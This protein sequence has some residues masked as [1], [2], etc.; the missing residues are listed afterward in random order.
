M[1]GSISA[2]VPFTR[3]VPRGFVPGSL[4]FSLYTIPLCTLLNQSGLKHHL[5]SYD[6][7]LCIS[8]DRFSSPSSTLTLLSEVFDRVQSWTAGNGLL[9]KS[10]QNRAPIFR[11]TQP[12]KKLNC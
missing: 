1:G 5:Y 8:F 3:G 9:L 4:L 10:V 7:R 12:L 2:P 11:T 6:T